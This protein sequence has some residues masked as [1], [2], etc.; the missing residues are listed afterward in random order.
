MLEGNYLQEK[1]I[2]LFLFIRIH[3]QHPLN[4]GMGVVLDYLSQ[5]LFVVRQCLDNLRNRCSFFG[6]YVIW[7]EE[8]SV[9]FYTSTNAQHLLCPECHRVNRA[10]DGTLPSLFPNNIPGMLMLAH[11]LFTLLTAPPTSTHNFFLS[12]LIKVI[13]QPFVLDLLPS[14]HIFSL[15]SLTVAVLPKIGDSHIQICEPE[16]LLHCHHFPL[17]IPLSL[18]RCVRRCLS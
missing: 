1:K 5:Y 2:V 6:I 7:T 13:P 10:H 9:L 16:R 14:Y 4:Q 18:S 11:K 3:I 17:R 12:C 8:L 15:Y